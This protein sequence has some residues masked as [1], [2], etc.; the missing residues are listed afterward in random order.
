MALIDDIAALFRIRLF[1]RQ[2][3]EKIVSA[4]RLV[5]ASVGS[6]SVK[7]SG[8][9]V[10]SA[11]TTLDFGSGFDVSESPAGEANVALDMAEA[12]YDNGSSM[13]SATNVQDA[14]DEL[15]G[16][17]GGG[18]NAVTVICDFG[19]SFTDKAQTVVTGEAW[20]STTSNIVAMVKTPNGVDPDEIRLLDLRPVIS[21][22]VAGDGFTVTLYS[23]PEA[24]GAY[25]VKCIGV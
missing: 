15:A 9:V 3:A 19:A 17:I 18:V 23:E 13:L 25:S 8:S 22:L 20:V 21:D 2:V 1:D 7:E 5:I 12:P 6:L 10:S 16:S 4:F 24:K 14:I 11:A